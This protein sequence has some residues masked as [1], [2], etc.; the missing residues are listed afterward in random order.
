MKVTPIAF[1][2]ALLLAGCQVTQVTPSPQ[3]PTQPSHLEETAIMQPD[4]ITESPSEETCLIDQRDD[5]MDQRLQMVK[6]TIEM[7]GVEDPNVLKAMRCVP[8]HEFVLEEYL[9]QAYDDH[10]LPIGYGQTISQPYIVAWMTEL[11]E[12]QPG[13]KVLEIGTG[14][15]YQ[16]AILAELGGLEVYSIEIVPELADIAE[17][18]LKRLGYA[19]VQ[20][21]QGDGYYGWSEDSLFDAI[22]VTAAPDHLPIPLVAQ[23]AE[24][25]RLVIPIGPQGGFQ[26]LWV[27][28][29]KQ[30]ELKAYNMGLVSFV[31]FTGEGVKQPPNMPPY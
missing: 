8:R 10:P 25:G 14:S 7:R 19:D 30:G 23:L 5:Y 17:Q 1:S 31:P 21:K 2:L 27:W 28:V 15:G 29:N 26:T 16:A 13:E 11:I 20:L 3:A 22:I 18:R 12:L 4:L 6:T 9:E 24:G